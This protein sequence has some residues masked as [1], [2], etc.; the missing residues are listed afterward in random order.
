MSV[1]GKE[2][3]GVKTETAGIPALFTQFCVLKEVRKF[4]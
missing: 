2:N 4:H 1:P 3:G